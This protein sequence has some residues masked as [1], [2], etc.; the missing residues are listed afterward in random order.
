MAVKKYLFDLGNV[1]FDW[2][3]KHIFKEIITDENTLDKFLSEIAFPHLDMR[4]DAGIKID[5][6][7]KEAI[8][9]LG[10]NGS[11]I[12]TKGLGELA[13]F[14]SNDTNDGKMLNRRVEINLSK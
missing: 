12:V 1:F 2:S 14:E 13:P 9:Q 4:C 8:I 3:P 11:R 6:A 7:V 5:K 10:V